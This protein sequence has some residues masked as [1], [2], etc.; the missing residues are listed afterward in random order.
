MVI[1]LPLPLRYFFGTGIDNLP[2]IYCPVSEALTLEISA[3]VPC[4]TTSPP[5]LPAPGPISIT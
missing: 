3:A 1:D 5:C 2:E 4:A